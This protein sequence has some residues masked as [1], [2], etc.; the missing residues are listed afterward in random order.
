MSCFYC[1]RTGSRVCG[2]HCGLCEGE[3]D[4][5]PDQHP[6]ERMFGEGYGQGKEEK[7]A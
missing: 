5:F 3:D 2:G 1:R 4:D 6:S 7:T